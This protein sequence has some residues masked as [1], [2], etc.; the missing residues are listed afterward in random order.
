MTGRASGRAPGRAAGPRPVVRRLAAP[1]GVAALLG[2]A[3]GFVGV[4]DPHRPGRYPACPLLAHT[5]LYCPGC[6]G[7]RGLYAL[8]HGDL[9]GALAANAL[10]V[11]GYAAFAVLWT[12]WTVRTLRGGEGLALALRPGHRWAL[13]SVVALFTVLRNLPWGVVPGP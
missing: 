8:V 9:P 7:L 12:V 2:S 5:G 3:A 1:L 10:A 13:G 6:G 4:V 11:A